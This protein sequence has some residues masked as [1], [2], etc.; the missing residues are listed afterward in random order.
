MTIS[1]ITIPAA[2]EELISKVKASPE[3]SVTLFVDDEYVVEVV[4][5]NAAA[6][7]I[8]VDPAVIVNLGPVFEV[9]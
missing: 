9:Q 3:P 1:E 2:T 4:F 8:V 6:G 7:S 5:T